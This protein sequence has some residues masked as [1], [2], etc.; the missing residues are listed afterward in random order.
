MKKLLSYLLPITEK[1]IQ[2]MHHGE[3][4]IVWDNGKKML[5]TKLS[6]YSYGSLQRVLLKALEAVQFHN[7]T[8]PVLILGMGMGSV[9]QSIRD[10]FKNKFPIDLVE[11]DPE[12]IALAQQEF[13]IKQYEP[14]QIF[15]TDAFQFVLGSNKKYKLVIVDVFIGDT[16]PEKFT[17][18]AFLKALSHLILPDGII[19]FNTMRNTL[20]SHQ[21]NNIIHTLKAQNLHIKVLERVCLT[22]DVII[23]SFE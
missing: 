18:S 14:F 13:N 16:I 4:E 20:N 8:Q 22:N 23:A 10:K 1:K 2:S 7:K 15:E 17:E 9:L 3:L 6:N 21:Q 19:I 12:I 5:D 11:F